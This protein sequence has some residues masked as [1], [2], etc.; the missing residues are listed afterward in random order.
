[1]LLRT[2]SLPKWTVCTKLC[3]LG[4]GGL[5]ISPS[6]M[7]RQEYGETIIFVERLVMLTNKQQFW[8]VNRTQ[9]SYFTQKWGCFYSWNQTTHCHTHCVVFIFSN[10]SPFGFEQNT[11]V[12]ETVVHSNILIGPGIFQYFSNYLSNRMCNVHCTSL[13]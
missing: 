11:Y 12:Q 3:Y 5:H 9:L 10:I 4:E 7:N 8:L 2:F 6:L 1:M 13:S